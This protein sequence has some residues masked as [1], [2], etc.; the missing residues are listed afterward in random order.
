MKVVEVFPKDVHVRLEISLR[1][2]KMLQ[3]Y[4]QSSMPFYNKV[5]E[6][7]EE[8]TF[9]EHNFIPEVRDV[10]EHVEKLAK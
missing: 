8:R 9:L 5:V 10:I 2:L 1:E 3:T 6:D 4:I 7:Y